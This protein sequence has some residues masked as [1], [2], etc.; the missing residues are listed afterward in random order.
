MLGVMKQ[1]LLFAKWSV[2]DCYNLTTSEEKRGKV[3]QKLCYLFI[4]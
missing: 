2:G 1:D 4:K 3:P